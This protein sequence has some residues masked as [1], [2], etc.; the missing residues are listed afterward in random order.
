MHKRHE[1]EKLPRATKDFWKSCFQRVFA[2][3]EAEVMELLMGAAGKQTA[4]EWHHVVTSGPDETVMNGAQNKS[5][6]FFFPLMELSH[7]YLISKN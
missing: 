5:F 1:S 3:C 7:F 4:Q 2:V 6:F